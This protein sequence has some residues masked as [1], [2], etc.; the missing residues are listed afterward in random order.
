[1]R[2]AINGSKTFG[3]AISGV[4]NNLKNKLL[5][6]ALDKAISGIGKSLSGGKGF[7]GFLGGLFGKERGGHVSAGGGYFVGERGRE[8]LQ[9]G[10][11]GG[12][13]IPNS[14]ISGGGVVNNV[15]V[16]VDASGTSVAGDQGGGKEFGQIIAAVVKSTIVEESRQGGLLNR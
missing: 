5:D 16:N 4:L 15:T 1:M 13:V 11:K 2:D 10:S 3:Q 7:T 12:N 6:I 9:M 8:I 14:K